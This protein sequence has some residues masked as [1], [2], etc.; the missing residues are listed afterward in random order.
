MVD[1]T[2]CS[3]IPSDILGSALFFLDEIDFDESQGVKKLDFAIRIR[4]NM[5]A[6]IAQGAAK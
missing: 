3:T 5:L 1:F 6:I 2:T 4:D